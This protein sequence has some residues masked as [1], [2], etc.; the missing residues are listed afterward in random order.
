MTKVARAF[1]ILGVEGDATAEVVEE[2]YQDLKAVW[3]P[4]RFADNPELYEKAEKK[5]VQIEEAYQLLSHHLAQEQTRK[6][7]AF[8]DREEG[9]ERGPSILDDTLSERMVKRRSLLPVW[10]GLFGLV[11]LAALI[12]FWNWSPVD[13]DI[14]EKRS[15]LERESVEISPGGDQDLEN[16]RI[17]DP[18][19]DSE[20]GREE[21]EES[22]LE[23]ESPETPPTERVR[24]DPP[25]P[26]VPK[27]PEPSGDRDDKRRDRPPPQT[28]EVETGREK[29]SQEVRPPAEEPEMPLEEPAAEIEEPEVSELAE[30]AFQILR[31]KSDLANRLIEG[32]IDRVTY[33]S[34][35]AVERDSSE[36]YVYLV[37]EEEGRE[38]HFVWS[39]E[40][41][42]QA[43]KPISHAAR[44]LAADER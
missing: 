36:V 20:G 10:L 27:K 42:T 3:N 11:A 23:A 40:V 17:E 19:S 29:A 2:A 13:T 37:A 38:V 32:A 44:A 18:E 30:R 41:E 21:V 1:Q 31:A 34:W 25:S 43:V 39:V 35:T 6:E 15:V 16:L 26:A 24:A 8:G 28:V 4:D 33:Q 7:Q 12:S 22:R 5:L 14:E 9:R